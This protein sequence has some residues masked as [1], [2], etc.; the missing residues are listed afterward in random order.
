MSIS[1]NEIPASIRVPLAYIEFDNSKAVTGTPAMLHKTLMLGT[2]L[3]SGTAQSGQAVRVLSHSHAVELFGQKSPLASMVKTFK[4]HNDI[5]D[6]WVLPLDEASSG[7][8]AKGKIK[9][10]GTATGSGT[11]Y[12]MVAGIQVSVGVEIGEEA[13]SIASKLHQVL[14][15]QRELIANVELSED[16]INLTASFKGETGNDIDIRANYY[17]G[18]TYPAGIALEITAMDGGA[19]NPDLNH[20][21]TGFGDTWWNYLINPFTDADNLN[22]LRAELVTRWGPMKQ[23][24]GMCFMAIRGT[25]AQATTFAENRN[26]HLFSTIATNNVPQPAF[27]WAAAYAAVASK[28]LS[29]DPARPLQ[30]LVMDLLPPKMSDRWDLPARNTLLYSGISTYTVN[31]GDQPQIEAAITMYRKNSFGDMDTSYLYVETIAT[32]SYLR[33]AIRSRIQTKYPRCKLAND[34]I[35]VAPGQAIVTPKVIRSELLALF[36]ELE[37]VGLVE[38]YEA[39]A[40][41]LIVERDQNDKCRLNVLSNENL[42]NQFR[43]YAHAIQF[44]L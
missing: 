40:E 8:A 15:A 27:I 4:A 6:L 11:L 43:I 34:G 16:T 20:A 28:S 2:K 5:A 33:Y 39:F 42:V 12:V 14:R 22:K 23:I 3:A 18:Q 32:L 21:I 13:A 7:V 37:F 1:Y 9:V 25:H 31:A 24:D 36:T 35:R 26:D 19:V 17:T 41:T 29:I 30:T 38:D 44:I 10:I